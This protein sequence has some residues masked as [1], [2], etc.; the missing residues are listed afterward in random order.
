MR[1]LRVIFKVIVFAAMVQSSLWLCGCV[2][3][4]RQ[5]HAIV[6]SAMA[7]GVNLSIP[8]IIQVYD[9]EKIAAI[10][11]VHEKGGSRAEAERAL[12]EVREQWRPVWVAIDSL[13]IAQDGYAGAIEKGSPTNM[14]ELLDAYCELSRAVAP[15]QPMPVIPG[16]TCEVDGG[17]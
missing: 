7:R 14:S 17:N 6:A 4:A 9:L 15:M 13:A 3:T 8:K 1:E 5:Q 10:R 11:A 12:Q 2:P 16:I